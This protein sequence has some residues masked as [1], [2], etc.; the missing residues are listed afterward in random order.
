MLLVKGRAHNKWGPPKGHVETGET[1]VA[2]AK[3]EL[4][5]ETGIDIDPDVL[6]NSDTVKFENHTFFVIYVCCDTTDVKERSIEISDITW[7]S[8]PDLLRWRRDVRH[9]RKNTMNFSL[10][11]IVDQYIT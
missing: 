3:R 2:A 9:Q 5:E 1:V 7:V 11:Y 10:R 6:I 8:I 4:K